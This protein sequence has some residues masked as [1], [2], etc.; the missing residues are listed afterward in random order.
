[1]TTESKQDTRQ[2]H[3]SGVSP[4]LGAA[5]AGAVTV[6]ALCVVAALVDGGRGLAGAAAGGVL[7]LVVFV[8]GIGLVNVAA[9][10]L[11][12]ASL[13]VALLTYT[14]QLLVLA[15]VV[16][17]LDRSGV[18]GEDLSRGWFAAAVIAVT[19]LWLVGQVVAATR[20][21]IPAFDVAP[22]EHPGGER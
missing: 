12:A 18:A 21:R 3:T 5:V 2:V 10:V 13:L 1:M 8:L 19:V 9:R 7:T 4:L 14:L 22:D 16:V 11:P 6:V 17:A 15:L 20:Q